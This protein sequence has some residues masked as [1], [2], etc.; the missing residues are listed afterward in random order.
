MEWHCWG[1][2]TS[3]LEAVAGRNLASSSG[4]PGASSVHQKKGVPV[5]GVLAQ[6]ATA[7]QYLFVLFLGTQRHTP[8]STLAVVG[9]CHPLW[10]GRSAL[11]I[12]HSLWNKV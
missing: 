10:V 8:A 9:L 6:S 1:V 11:Q 2:L 4:R 12:S 3:K 5:P 7:P